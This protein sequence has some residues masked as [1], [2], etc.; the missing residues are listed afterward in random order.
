ML[1]PLN[2][3][4]LFFSFLSTREEN[5]HGSSYLFSPSDKTEG[6]A[7][8]GPAHGFTWASLDYVSG[9]VHAEVLILGGL[10][11]RHDLHF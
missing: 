4:C 10:Y 9:L 7:L 6:H 11:Q 3:S 1:L 5:A 8:Q 2:D